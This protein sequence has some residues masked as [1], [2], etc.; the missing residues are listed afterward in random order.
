M[1]FI[2]G[3]KLT[4]GAKQLVGGETTSGDVLRAKQLREEMV[5]GQNVPDSFGDF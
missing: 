3:A 4:S 1:L 5:W 2:L